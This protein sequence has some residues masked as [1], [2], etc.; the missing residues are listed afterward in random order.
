[1]DVEQK[2]YAYLLP[3]LIHRYA[4]QELARVYYEARTSV[5]VA[6]PLVAQLSFVARLISQFD[7]FD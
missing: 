5:T 6:A 1:M 4:W 7:C 2:I 3:V